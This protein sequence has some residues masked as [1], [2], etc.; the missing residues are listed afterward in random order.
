MWTPAFSQQGP[1]GRLGATRCV[2][3]GLANFTLIPHLRPRF[4][5]VSG[6]GFGAA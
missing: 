1:H 2:T 5:I 3:N 6:R 4:L